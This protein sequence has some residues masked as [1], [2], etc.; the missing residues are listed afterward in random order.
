MK[1]KMSLLLILIFCSSAHADL[2][3][4][5]DPLIA[6]SYFI[7]FNETEINNNY[8]QNTQT[9]IVTNRDPYFSV[10]VENWNTCDWG[11]GFDVITDCSGTL[12]P[13]S[14]CTVQIGFHPT[15]VGDKS[16][17][18]IVNPKETGF[19]VGIDLMGRGVEDN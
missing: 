16:C 11:I 17:R 12:E 6:D 15:S 13:N 18:V 2:I 1:T 9:V 7:H 8:L 5:R 3:P 19:I 10:A 14:S 4:M